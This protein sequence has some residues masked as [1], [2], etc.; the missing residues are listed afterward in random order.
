[1]KKV[2]IVIDGFVIEI[3][4]PKKTKPAVRLLILDEQQKEIKQMV[5]ISSDKKRTFSVQ[6]VDAKGRP[7]AIDGVPV[8]VLAAPGGVQLFP[9]ADGLSCEVAWVE[10]KTGIVLTVTGD[11]DLGAGVKAITG[12]VDIETLTAEAVGFAIATGPE[13]DV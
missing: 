3:S 6:P 2:S 4:R 5:T 13:V 12:S 10:P 11:A 1:M 7:A 9:S 8:W